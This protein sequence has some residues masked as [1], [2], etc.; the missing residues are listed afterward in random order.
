MCARIWENLC[1]ILFGKVKFYGYENI[2]LKLFL[3]I[4]DAGQFEKLIL[5]G[6]GTLQDCLERWE[7]I[8]EKNSEENASFQYL[9]YVSLLKGYASLLAQHLE[10]KILLQKAMLQVDEETI[11]DL[12]KIGYK[13]DITL[14]KAQLKEIENAPASEMPI[15]EKQFR[16]FNYAKSIENA[17]RRSNTLVTKIGMKQSELAQFNQ[18]GKKK[19]DSSFEDVIASLEVALGDGRNIFEDITLAK[20]NAL[21]KIARKKQEAYKKHSK[22]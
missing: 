20:Y 15:L 19:E 12:G 2:P 17:A 7:K 8:I 9:S 3:D 5:S 4:A 1:A 21:K 10:V 11:N 13:L 16:S 6:K 18:T 14:T 22:K